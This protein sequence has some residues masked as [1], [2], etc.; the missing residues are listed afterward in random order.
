MNETASIPPAHW[1]HRHGSEALAALDQ[2]FLQ[3]LDRHDPTIR[4]WIEDYRQGAG[5]GA[6]DEA[7]A[8]SEKLLTTARALEVF[9]AE[10]LGL[11]EPLARLRQRL[12]AEEAV[13]RFRDEFV[14]RR[15]RKPRPAPQDDLA[16]L[17]TWLWQ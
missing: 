4:G 10:Q 11:A 13:V 15:A 9:L 7:V 16:T 1:P 6:P 14:E 5:Q 12:V 17:S 2:A 8:T 3:H